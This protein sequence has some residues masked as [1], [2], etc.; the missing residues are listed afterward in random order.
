MSPI[1]IA[2]TCF[3]AVILLISARGKLIRNEKVVDSVTGVGMPVRHFPKL[4]LLECFGAIG[5]V[6]GLLVRPIGIAAAVGVTLYFLLAVLSHLR[7]RDLA[8]AGPAAF[9]LLLSGGTL[10]LQLS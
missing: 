2:T 10:A 7:K 1:T 9:I 4:A 6:L 3:L 8:G 5:V